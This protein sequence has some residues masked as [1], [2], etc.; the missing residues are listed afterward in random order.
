MTA[1]T[2]SAARRALALAL[3]A[4]AS[5]LGLAEAARAEA[6]RSA[7]PPI[8][9]PGAPGQASRVLSAEEATRL[10]SASFTPRTS[11]SCST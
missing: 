11:P 5:A 7:S 4:S 9:Q 2:A 8:V 10:A 1:T 3:L 6:A